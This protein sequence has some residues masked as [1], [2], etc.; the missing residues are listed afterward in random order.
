MTNK[1]TAAFHTLGCKVNQYETEAL[2]EMFRERG[3]ETAEFDEAADVY[4]INTC[5][6]TGMSDRKSR[7][8][9]RKA[10]RQNPEAVVVVT[11]CYPQTA[12]DEVAKIE[13]VDI[14]TGTANRSELPGLVEDYINGK[15]D[16]SDAEARRG[17]PVSHVEDIM[18]SKNYEETKVSSFR[19]RTRAYVK[20]QDGCNRFCTYCIIPY[21][22]GPVRSRQ[23]ELIVQEIEK[24]SSE[25]FREVVLT[26][27]H[28]ASYGNDFG[29]DKA[30]KGLIDIVEKI[31][32]IPGIERIRLSSLEP[33]IITEAFIS[34]AKLLP[35]LCPHYHISLQSGCDATLKRMNRRYT[36][37][38]YMRAV[39]E[40]K[41]NIA[42]VSVTTDVMVGFPGE[43][44]EEFEE[45]YEFLKRVPLTQMHIFKYSQR[46]GTPAAKYE[47]QVTPQVKEERS[48]RLLA[49]SAKKLLE[50]NKGFE[51]RRLSVLFEQEAERMDGMFEGRTG[52]YI[53]VLC[54]G[55]DLHGRS[56][57]V[58][59]KDAIDDYVI[60][61][62]TRGRFFC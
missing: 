39:K 12:P 24:L 15:Y 59:L 50:Y 54:P 11:G 9:V 27:I 22:R 7:N 16:T 13:G 41:A 56:G 10:R 23:P 62:L 25:G 60:G 30:N 14:I 20:I 6:V 58:L 1:R 42:D 26:G 2:T 61:E 40:L 51:G 49:L 52:N 32:D 31:H 5:T 47:N 19:D 33:V 36:A 57:T 18:R 3:F 48:K 53:R 35:K 28:L 44:D 43:T 8:A 37:E 4:V 29:G 45:T 55:T 38:E 46:K 21:A 34:R 17:M